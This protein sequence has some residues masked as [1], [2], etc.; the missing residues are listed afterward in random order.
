M[1]DSRRRVVAALSPFALVA[2]CR[3]P[4]YMAGPVLG[5]WAWLPTMVL[6]WAC[7]GGLIAWT[8]GSAAV[9]RWLR[10]AH[11]SWGWRL[12]ALGMGLLSLPG[13]VEHWH[14]LRTPSILFLSLSIGLINPWFEEAYW[15][16][17]LLDATDRLGGV[18]SVGYSA[19]WFAI[20]HPLIW[21]VHST[22][23]RHWIVLPAL[24]AVGIV[25]ALVYRRSGSL[26]WPIAGHM[27]ANI[28]GLSVPVLLNIHAPHGA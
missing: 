28:F 18:L 13:F 17:L 14:V 3:A 16:G 5:V 12:L 1:T 8:A 15:R 11:G 22:A 25:W 27:C 21:G 23:L 10:P 9:R 4:Q 20:S 24:A 2:V 26:R 7:I 19:A 6:L